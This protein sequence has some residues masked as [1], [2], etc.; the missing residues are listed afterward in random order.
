MIYVAYYRVSTQKQG[1]SGLGLDA[2]KTAVSQ[3]L[4]G[5][6]PDYEYTEIESGK[7]NN[8]I[9]LKKAIEKAKRNDATLIIA[10][11]DRLSRN[12]GFIFALRDSGCKFVCADMPEANTLNIG[13]LAV[14][15]QH[16]RE[17]IS[18]RVKDALSEKKKRGELLGTSSTVNFT[19]KSRAMGNKA[20]TKLA[21][22]NKN[23]HRIIDFCVNHRATGFSLTAI[24]N[25]LND[26][27]FD[28]RFSERVKNSD[29]S[30]NKGKSKRITKF[31]PS[32]VKMYLDRAARSK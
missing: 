16:E 11:L 8:R 17:I 12:A 23:N 10:K 24:A 26:L 3:F 2:Q 25:K 4:K 13:I 1:A 14:M 31:Y 20:T 7:K 15:A 5:Q 32:T 6:S 19:A 30:E 29:P 9:V 18:K 27:E 22:E 28:T 21:S